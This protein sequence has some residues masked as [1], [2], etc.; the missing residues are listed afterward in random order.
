[1]RA[2]LRGFLQEHP[3]FHL[4]EVDDDKDLCGC[5]CIDH[6]HPEWADGNPELTK[7]KASLAA[8]SGG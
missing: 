4:V 6:G 8:S 5:H 3:H 2:A 7:D 1:M